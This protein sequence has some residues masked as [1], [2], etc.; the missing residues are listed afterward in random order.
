MLT[1]TSQEENSRTFV[2][3]NGSQMPAKD[4]NHREWNLS[5]FSIA[6][7]L[8]SGR[9]GRAYLAMERQSHFICCLKYVH[10]GRMQSPTQIQLLAREV[11][12]NVNLSHENILRMYGYFCEQDRFFF[13][14]EYA[15]Q[16]DL[17]NLLKSQPGERFKEK[18]ASCYVRQLVCALKYLHNKNVLHRDIKPENILIANVIY[19]NPRAHSN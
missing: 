13:I 10:I 7:P 14:L 18:E 1:T 15:D 9:F 12:I 8:G 19:S 4:F 11:E 2:S 17:Y 6:K 3:S 16:G 5:R